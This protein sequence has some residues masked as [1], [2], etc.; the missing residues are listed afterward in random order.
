MFNEGVN[1]LDK[2]YL[3]TLVIFMPHN[4][5]VKELVASCHQGMQFWFMVLISVLH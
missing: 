2:D 1:Y 5:D 3:G 4:R